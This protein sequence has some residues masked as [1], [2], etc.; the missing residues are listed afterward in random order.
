MTAMRDASLIRELLVAQRRE[1]G[2]V[3]RTARRSDPTGTTARP[4]TTHGAELCRFR[5]ELLT[6]DTNTLRET[7]HDARSRSSL[8]ELR[9][10]PMEEIELVEDV[11]MQPRDDEPEGPGKRA[12]DNIEQRIAPANRAHHGSAVATAQHAIEHEAE[13]GEAD[14]A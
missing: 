3:R 4:A 2:S 5:R 1:N 6:Q 14:E 10:A 12:D 7:K 13:Y 11:Q 8:Q 9:S